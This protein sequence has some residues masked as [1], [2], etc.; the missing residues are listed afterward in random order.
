MMVNAVILYAYEKLNNTAPLETDRTN[1][2][3]PTTTSYHRPLEFE[4]HTAPI[5][6][7]HVRPGHRDPGEPRAFITSSGGHNPPNVI[8]GR[9]R[10]K[11]NQFGPYNVS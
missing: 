1:V 2:L 10:R 6:T 9:R 4:Y 11:S 8:L 5:S 3:Q 7:T